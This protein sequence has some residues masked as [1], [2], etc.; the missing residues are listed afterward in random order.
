MA[1]YRYMDSGKTSIPKKEWLDTMREN[2][3]VRAAHVNLPILLDV[4]EFAT[5]VAYVFL[6]VKDNTDELD[7]GLFVTMNWRELMSLDPSM[8]A[9]PDDERVQ[10]FNNV[11]CSLNDLSVVDDKNCDGK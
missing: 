10:W 4:K 5:S 1:M 8:I 9:S 11:I 7:N 6:W 3:S 2:S